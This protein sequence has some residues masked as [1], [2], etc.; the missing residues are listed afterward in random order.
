MSI[1]LEDAAAYEVGREYLMTINCAGER[2]TDYIDGVLVFA[3]DDGDI[4][5]GAIALYCWGNVDARF[6]EVRV[7]PRTWDT[8]YA[9]AREHVLP[10]GTR[11]QVLSGNQAEAPSAA[12]RLGLCGDSLRRWPIEDR[13]TCGRREWSY[14]FSPATA[15]SSMGDLSGPRTTMSPSMTF[16]C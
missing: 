12:D 13:P 9:F 11:V 8:C 5:S 6:A 7:A 1:L 10:A 3:V 16:V 14:A 4:A 2:L 15:I